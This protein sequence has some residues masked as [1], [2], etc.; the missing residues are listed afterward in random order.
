MTFQLLGF[1]NRKV[2]GGKRMSMLC[3]IWVEKNT[4]GG[5]LMYVQLISN[6]TIIFYVIPVCEWL[7]II[8]QIHNEMIR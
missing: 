6:T 1:N 2:G 5:W 4:V 3:E 7:Y 8:K